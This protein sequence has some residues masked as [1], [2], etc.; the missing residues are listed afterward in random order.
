MNYGYVK[1]STETQNIARQMAEMKELG[2][3]D[4]IHSFKK[5]N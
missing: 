2:L 3:S 1:V 4:N 5:K